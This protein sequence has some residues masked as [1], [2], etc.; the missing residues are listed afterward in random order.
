MSENYA[1]LWV[2]RSAN[3]TAI[4]RARQAI[5][6]LGRA[7]PCRVVKVS[8][9]IVTVAFEVNAA[10]YTLPNITIPKSESTWIRMP[11]QVGDKGVTMPADAYLGGVSGLGGGVATL[12]RPGNLSAL[13]FVPV[14]NSGSGPDDPNAAQV[15]GPN[16]AIIRTTT[17]T[18]SSIVTNDEGT[19]ITFGGTTLVI[20]A[21]GITMTANG[22]TFTWGGTQAVSTMP[23]KA[24]DVI[25]PNGSAN[26]HYHPG[27]QT[28][29]GNTGTMTG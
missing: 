3:Q 8:G 21:A 19:T 11:T 1:K 16:G 26:G 18:A 6:N 10:P 22:Q 25:L 9:A 5:D 27:V 20:N 7:L 15:C 12:T 2:Q 29:T 17:G 13:V 24:P 4:N 23:I 14:S 28:G